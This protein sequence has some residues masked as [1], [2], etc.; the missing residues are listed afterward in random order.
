MF[1]NLTDILEKYLGKVAYFLQTQIHFSSIVSGIVVIVP[2]TIIGG[3]AT[4]IT[5][6]P[7][8]DAVEKGS[9]LYRIF[10]AWGNLAA[11]GF[12]IFAKM[13]FN[14]TFGLLSLYVLIA[15]TV[16]LADKYKMNRVLNVITSM[17]VFIMI[18]APITTLEETTAI[19]IAYLDAKGLFTAMIVACGTIEISRF[20]I[21]RNIKFCLPPSVPPSISAPFEQLIPMMVNIVVFYVLSIACQRATGVVI[22]QF[23]LNIMKP[24]L[25]T[26][27]TVWAAAIYALLLNGLWMVGVHGGNIVNSVMAPFFLINLTANAA[28]RAAGEEMTNVLCTNWHILGFNYGGSGVALALVLAAIIVAKSQH[29]RS[30]TKLGFVPV[31]FNVSEPVVFG[32]PIVLNAYLALPFLLL[33][34]FNS[35]ITYFCMSVGIVGKIFVAVPAN[36]PTPLILFLST[37]DWKAPVLW[38]VLLVIDVIVYMPFVK[39]FDNKLLKDEKEAGTEK[40]A[41]KAIAS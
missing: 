2:L 40:E 28:A 26:T 15:I 38:L 10:E 32:Y 6:V 4:I 33:G 30:V 31:L 19:P 7:A 37:M 39:M 17:L 41:I 12:G 3:F 21:K 20:L 27:D 23:I 14:L 1:K 13:I 8:T 22:P 24:L 9:L 36:L 34:V 25:S 11:S 18:A 5:S 16:A 29:L 35:V